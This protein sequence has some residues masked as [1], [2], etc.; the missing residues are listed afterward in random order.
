[1]AAIARAVD[2]ILSKHGLGYRFRTHTE[3]N[4]ISVT[5]IVFHADGH[6]EENTLSAGA[7]TTGSKNAIQS[8][9]SA[10]SYLSR[11]TLKAALGLAASAD[12]D[13]A[14][15]GAG[16]TLTESQIAELVDL[17]EKVGADKPKFCAYMRVPSL[18]EIP[19]SKFAAAIAALNA[20]GKR[21]A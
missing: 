12:D 9:G 8:L 2:P 6:A 15:C 13:G 20:K 10:V 1:M 21:N 11:Y 19:P 17:C 5:C 3:N 16:E 4:V 18:A 14:S 7:D